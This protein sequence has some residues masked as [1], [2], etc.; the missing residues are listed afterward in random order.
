MER[1]K[2]GRFVKGHKQGLK[3]G[4]IP[5]NKR[6]GKSESRYRPIKLINGRRVYVSHIIW[7]KHNHPYVP[8]GF[9]IHHIDLN[10]SNN[11]INNLVI[12][13]NDLHDR[14]HKE[15]SKCLM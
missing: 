2:N 12:M 4:H 13:P 14:L 5:W 1:D 9:V 3:K 6:D 7:C 15:I 11:K 10:P 8:K